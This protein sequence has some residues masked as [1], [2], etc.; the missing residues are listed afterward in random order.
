MRNLVILLS[1]VGKRHSLQMSDQPE[2]YSE[3]GV[4][5]E[6]VDSVIECLLENDLVIKVELNDLSTLIWQYYE[7]PM[8]KDSYY[9]QALCDRLE[10]LCSSKS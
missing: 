10:S 3:G 1:S 2:L 9:F 5:R 7:S 8:P 6:I 4:C